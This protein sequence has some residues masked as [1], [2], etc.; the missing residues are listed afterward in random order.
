MFLKNLKARARLSRNIFMQDGATAHT[1]IDTKKLLSQIFQRIIG[2]GF[3]WLSH[4][5]E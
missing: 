3:E 5:P 4:L 1:A 2:R